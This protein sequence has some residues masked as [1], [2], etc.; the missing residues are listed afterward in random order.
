MATIEA[1]SKNKI[2][3]L[4]KRR[5]KKQKDSK[6]RTKRSVSGK[7][8]RSMLLSFNRHNLLWVGFSS[9]R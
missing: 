8:S 5:G 3:N 4:T 2:K 9:Y 1:D 7:R 6:C